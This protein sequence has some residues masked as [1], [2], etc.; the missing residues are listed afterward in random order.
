MERLKNK[1]FRSPNLILVLFLLG[2]ENA[3]A[4]HT[5]GLGNMNTGC[6]GLDGVVFNTSTADGQALMSKCCGT[7]TTVTSGDPTCVGG[8]ISD[9][10]Q[11]QIQYTWQLNKVGLNTLHHA[12]DLGTITSTP[13]TLPTPTSSTTAP[14]GAASTAGGVSNNSGTNGFE[15]SGNGQA[16]NAAAGAGGAGKGGGS[17]SGGGGGSS[18]TSGFGG[19]GSGGKKDDAAKGDGTDGE[20]KDGRLAYVQGAGGANGAGNGG[21]GKVGYDVG[22]N[23]AFGN[24]ANGL[25]PNGGAGG[26]NGLANE[27]GPPGSAQDAADYFSRT[28]KSDSIFKIV[29]TAYVRKK[30]LWRVKED[31][32]K[33][34]K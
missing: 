31:E 18:G 9:S 32:L 23:L 6:L 24:G 11:Q 8:G 1:N 33:L 28:N 5:I 12:Q 7:G 30:S 21:A 17:G 13:G 4:R 20:G 10:G 2:G 19:L 14:E 16:T 25:D 34:K 22:D 3:F 15:G 26:A 27:D 29:T